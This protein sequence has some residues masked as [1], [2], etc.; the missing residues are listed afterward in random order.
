MMKNSEDIG[1]EGKSAAD[2]VPVELFPE[3]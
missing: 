3:K 2:I 1:E